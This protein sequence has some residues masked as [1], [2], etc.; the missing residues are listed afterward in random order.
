MFLEKE[1]REIQIIE[2]S[3]F[4]GC[5]SPCFSEEE[6]RNYI[7]SIRKEFSDATHVCTAYAI[8][9]KNEIRRC[10]DNQ[11]PSGTAGMPMLE[12]ILSSGCDN[13][14]ACTVRYFGGVKLGTGGLVRA[15]GGIIRSV[16][17]HA[18]KLIAVLRDEYRVEY[19]YDLSGVLETW[20]RTHTENPSFQYGET[21]SC[22]FL[23]DDEH[24]KETIRDLTRGKTEAQFLRH[25]FRNVPA[26][27]V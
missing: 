24:L 22:V 20:L 7:S 21:V 9:S 25:T 3:R 1:C 17:E 16:L 27:S 14:C 11:E 26:T 5:V 10:S 4:I 23:T 13:T 19:S 12:A 15:Y 8:G 18:P 2:R 6:A